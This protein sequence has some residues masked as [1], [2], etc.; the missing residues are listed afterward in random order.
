MGAAVFVWGG[1]GDSVELVPKKWLG[2][3]RYV[4]GLSLLREREREREDI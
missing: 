3:E 4:C 2:R 1:G